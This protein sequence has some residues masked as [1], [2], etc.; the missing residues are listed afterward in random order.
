MYTTLIAA[1]EFEG[2]VELEQYG[3]FGSTP[4]L[5]LHRVRAVSSD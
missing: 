1:A 4:R 2:L 5:R 3:G